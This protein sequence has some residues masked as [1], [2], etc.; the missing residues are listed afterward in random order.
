[1]GVATFEY[2][3]TDGMAMLKTKRQVAKQIY[4]N[5]IKGGKTGITFHERLGVVI[6]HFPD[7]SEEEIARRI[8]V[9]M[10][11][12]QSEGQKAREGALKQQEKK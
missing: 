2:R 3:I 7:L 4:E 10:N 11:T 1:M 9:D 8:D 6:E 5:A 12:A